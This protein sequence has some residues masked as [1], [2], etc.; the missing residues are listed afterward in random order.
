MGKKNVLKGILFGAI[1]FVTLYY[2]PVYFVNLFRAQGVYLPKF[3]TDILLYLAATIA[4]LTF[5]SS[6][7]GG[8]KGA[9]VDLIKLAPRLYYTITIFN[10]ISEIIVKINYEGQPITMI[11]TIDFGLIFWL[12][13]FGIVLGVLRGILNK[14]YEHKKKQEEQKF[15][16]EE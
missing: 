10:M 4:I 11:I 16:F 1:D 8:L 12:T 2:L 9:L 15:E 6:A 13:I 5:T 14:I 7:L 3:S